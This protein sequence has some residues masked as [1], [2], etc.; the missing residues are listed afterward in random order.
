MVSLFPVKEFFHSSPVHILGFGYLQ[1]SLP[2]FCAILK[3]DT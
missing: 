1:N 3:S 2:H